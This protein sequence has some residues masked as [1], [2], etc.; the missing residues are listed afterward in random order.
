M[1]ETVTPAKLLKP[2]S[3]ALLGEQWGS[4]ISTTVRHPTHPDLSPY[5]EVRIRRQDLTERYHKLDP[6]ADVR[7][8]SEPLTVGDPDK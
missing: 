5:I 2:G 7:I 4:V 1:H 8:Q 6:G 3:L